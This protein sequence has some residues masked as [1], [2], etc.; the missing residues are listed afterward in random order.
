MEYARQPRRGHRRLQARSPTPPAAA[1]SRSRATC[2]SPRRP[3]RCRCSATR[4]PREEIAKLLALGRPVPRAQPTWSAAYALGK[5]QRLIALLRAGGLGRADLA[6]RRAR[7]A[8]R[9]STRRSASTLGELRPA[10]GAKQDDLAG[11]IVLAPPGAIA[12]R[13]SRRLPEP[14]A[15]FASGWMRV[16]AARPAARHRAAAGHLRPRRL[17]RADRDH[18]RDGRR[19]GVGHAWAGGGAGA[20]HAQLQRHR[21]RALRLV[22]YEERGATDAVRAPSP[23][24][25]TGWSSRRRATPS[26]ALLADY[27]AHRRPIPT[28]AGRSPRS[29]AGCSSG[30]RLAASA[31][32][33]PSAIDP[34]LFALSLDYVGDIGRDH[35]ADLAGEAT[36]RARRAP[37]SP[38][39]SRRCNRAAKRRGAGDCSPAG[40]TGST[41]PGAGRCSSSSPARS[42]SASRRGSPRPA[43]A[44]WSAGP[45]EPRSRRSGTG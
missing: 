20:L 31:T 17:G 33:V 4:R 21:G 8:L 19:R 44:E 22:G 34:V 9:R 27:F 14:V 37:R 29:P 30:C 1:S 6:A 42:A 43:L 2:S 7:R 38:T 15:G 16:R 45:L 12:D 18:R 13:W 3:S 23:R 41:P 5:C 35:R 26:C 11:A 36:R 32:L 39:S 40:S 10:T 24:S 28:A 25:S